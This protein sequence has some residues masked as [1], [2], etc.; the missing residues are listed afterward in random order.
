MIASGRANTLSFY[1]GHPSSDVVC[2]NYHNGSGQ[3]KYS[4]GPLRYTEAAHVDYGEDAIYMGV[5]LAKG[6]QCDAT[7]TA[8]TYEVQGEVVESYVNIYVY[9]PNGISAP[10]DMTQVG[11]VDSVTVLGN[12][13]VSVLFM[14]EAQGFTYCTITRQVG[15]ETATT[16][17]TYAAGEGGSLVVKYPMKETLIVN[18]TCDGTEVEAYTVEPFGGCDKSAIMF[19]LVGIKGSAEYPPRVVTITGRSCKEA[20]AAFLAGSPRMGRAGLVSVVA[21]AM[22]G[23]A[24]WREACA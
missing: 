3:N 5:S 9:V 23:V 6:N 15:S 19:A 24:F 10:R 4:A 1:N 8:K 17:G 2:F 12:K 14:H 20:P 21:L 22:L 7:H 18:Y 16:V 13:K 11:G